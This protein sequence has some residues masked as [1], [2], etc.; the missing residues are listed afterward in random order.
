MFN[1]FENLGLSYILLL[2]HQNYTAFHQNYIAY[3]LF[4]LGGKLGQHFVIV[5]VF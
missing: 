2:I 5:L 3:G 1:K 4:I